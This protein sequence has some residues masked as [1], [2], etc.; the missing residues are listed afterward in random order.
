[1]KGLAGKVC[2]VTGGA[3]GIGRATARVLAGYGARVVV[4]DRDAEGGEAVAAGIRGGGGHARFVRADIGVQADLEGVADAVRGDPGHVDVL[5]NIA[6]R[7]IFGTETHSFAPWE[8][9]IRC[10]AGAYSVLTTLLLPLM[11]GRRAS[12]VNMSSISALIAQPGFGTYAASKAAVSALT[13]CMAADFAPRGVRV[14]AICPGTVWTD[15]NAYHIGR[16]HGVDRAGADAH[17]EIGGRHLLRR[18]ADPEEI[19]EAI[20]FLASD[21]SSFVTGTELVVDGGYTV[22]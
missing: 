14:N 15:N 7:P 11:E 16:E 5:V 10:S 9:V 12:V 21:S 3:A 20:A 19:G 8:E 2:V 17:P 4:V 18:C 6:S 22:V 1:M 13:R